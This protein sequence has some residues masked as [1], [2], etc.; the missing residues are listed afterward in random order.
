MCACLVFDSDK[1]RIYFE[2]GRDIDNFACEFF[3][4]AMWGKMKKLLAI[5]LM[6]INSLFFTDISFAD[7]LPTININSSRTYFNSGAS[8]FAGDI[9]PP[10]KGPSVYGVA[11]LPV[12]PR[13][14]CEFTKSLR[15]QLR[16]CN[17][18]NPPNIG[19]F[20]YKDNK[21]AKI[22]PFT[23]NVWLEPNRNVM[24][25]GCG[26]AGG[27]LKH[28]IPNAPFGYDFT[29][30]CNNHDV[31]YGSRFNKGECDS[32]F[33]REMMSTCGGSGACEAAAQ[34]YAK[35]VR[36]YGAGPYQEA[37][38]QWYCAL[39]GFMR[40]KVGQYYGASLCIV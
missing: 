11:Y 14:E 29:A 39:F 22:D 32:I 36:E 7:V 37:V 17:F 23:K 6:L 31:C 3:N 1:F 26:P 30:A 25:N 2:C 13:M 4:N 33:E 27:W 24:Q 40:G 9:G 20:R 38:D 15:D 10:A 28:V 12:S 35:A 18:A 34:G 5:I 8:D 21:I 16:N 19:V